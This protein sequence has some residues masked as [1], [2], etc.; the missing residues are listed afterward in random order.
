ML[1][2]EAKQE[3]IEATIALKR[4]AANAVK[5][6]T[7][8]KFKEADEEGQREIIRVDKNLP[9]DKP[10]ENETTVKG[11]KDETDLRKAM[12]NAL[13]D[14]AIAMKKIDMARQVLGNAYTKDEIETAREALKEAK[15]E[16]KKARIEVRSLD[17]EKEKRKEQDDL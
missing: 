16:M 4:S 2:R 17:I 14:E 12:K 8:Q 11:L 10:I 13:K 7:A 6:E 3:K 15:K 9:P 1:I 5:D